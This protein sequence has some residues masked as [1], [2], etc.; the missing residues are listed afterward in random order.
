[1][2]AFPA[3]AQEEPVPD[4]FSD[5]IDVRVVNVEAVVTSRKGERVRGLQASDFELRIDDEQVSIDYFAEIDD[6]IARSS[7]AAKAEGDGVR[8]VPS[9][10]PDEPVGTNYL[11]FI[12]E[13]FAI[14]RDRDR[15]LKQ[16][17][18]DLTRL[19]SHD[20]VA[21]VAFDGQDVSRLSDWTGSEDRMR[22]ALAAARKRKA[23]GLMRRADQDPLEGAVNAASTWPLSRREQRIQRSVLAAVA[24]VR[25][26]A[27]APGRKVML[28]LV[29]GWSTPSWNTGQ[30][31]LLRSPPSVEDLYGPLVHAANLVG[32]TLYPVDLAGFR[33]VFEAGATRVGDASVGHYDPG[34]G[35]GGA[36]EPSAFSRPASFNL[37]W[38]QE[39]ALC[40]LAHET[41]GLPMINALRDSALAA[42][43]T[44]TRSY[45]WF[46]FAP[47]RNRDDALHDIEVRLAGRPD[48]RVR[49]RRSY[50]DLSKSTEVTMMVEGAVLFGGAPGKE[51]LGVRLGAP[52]RT[53]GRKILVPMEIAIPLD[54]VELLPIGN[55]WMNEL[56]F[57]V[58][59]INEG[60]ERSETP[61]EKIRISG[62]NEP[63]PGAIFVYETTLLLRSSEHRYVASVLD[64]LTGGI[65]SARGAVGPR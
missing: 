2:V 23:L 41:G 60:G 58:T 29:D 35:S 39:A 33:P 19:G 43:A 32:Y 31:E 18:R 30:F 12:D 56:E 59:V 54:D 20:R 63:A 62:P 44:D 49:A 1:M 16:L 50:F 3:T 6:G 64:P 46:G 27:D 61:I 7:E 26:F 38:Y 22:D 42:T 48:L 65:L 17:E 52:N 10:Q 11:V 13:Y 53:R 8:A 51:T 28:V 4:L 55:Q 15:V 34:R 47:P 14:R 37:E 25:S 36:T 45:Y 5:V 9:L 21:V 24:T 57:R 40:Y